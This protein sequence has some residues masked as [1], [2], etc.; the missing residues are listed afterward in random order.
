MIKILDNTPIETYCL[1]DYFPVYVKR[2]DLSCPAPGPPFAKVRGLYTRMK[3]LKEIENVHTVGYTETSISMAGWG[4][5]WVAKELGMRA[6]IYDPQYKNPPELLLYHREQWKKFGAVLEPIKA[7]MAK[8]NYNICSKLL[9][10]KYGDDAVMFPLGLPFIE[11]IDAVAREAVA[12]NLTQF[13]T[14]VTCV[15]SGT[16]CAG[17]LRGLME[18]PKVERSIALYGII[19]RSGDFLAKRKRIM[20]KVEFADLFYPKI[21]FTIIDT[22]YEYTQIE[23][24]P[25]P[26]PCHPYYDRKA[27][28]WMVDN[29]HLLNGP[30]LFWNIGA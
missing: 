22:G 8:V 9:H 25:C 17:I 1:K 16:M 18:G 29:H 3:H 20:D 21:N 13:G 11:T 5:A 30:V 23:K 15:G 10:K 12:S 27:W 14:I 6:V 28:K 19:T 24:E 26:F 7:G 2:E 4:V